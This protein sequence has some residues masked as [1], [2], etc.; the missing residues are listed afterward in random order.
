MPTIEFTTDYAQRAARRVG[1]VKFKLEGV[2]LA[3]RTTTPESK[4]Y[5]GAAKLTIEEVRAMRRWAA[6]EGFGLTLPQ[7]CNE[8]HSLYPHLKLGS[9]PEILKNAT[10]FD[11]SYT[12]GEPDRDWWGQH[13]E[14]S[15]PLMVL[16][17]LR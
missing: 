14:R 3:R 5:R 9:F 11:P 10:W 15:L 1:G 4:S 13:A 16:R 2:R 8:L 7:Q 12:P 6:R 17:V